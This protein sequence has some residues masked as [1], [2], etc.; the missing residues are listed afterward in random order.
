MTRR[1][2]PGNGWDALDGVQPDELP[3]VTVVLAHYDQQA[4]LDRSLAALAA[5]DYPAERVQVVVADD[6]SPEAPTVP[7]GVQLVRQADRGFRLAAVRNLGAAHATGEVL[8]FIDADCAPEPGYLRAATR[9]PAL[10]PEAVVVGRRRHAELDGVEGAIERIGPAHELE[11]PAWLR[12][13]YAGTRNLL[14]V[15]DRSYR[16]VIGASITTSR[17]F[18]ERVGGFDETFDA[19]GGEDWEWTHRAWNAGAVLAHEPAAVLWHNGPE[20]AERDDSDEAERI[21]RQNPESIALSRRIAVPGSAGRGVRAAHPHVL[22]ELVGEHRDTAVFATVDALL[23]ALPTAQ[24]AVP[25]ASAVLFPHDDRV[26]A[27][28]DASTR[29]GVL[30]RVHEPLLMADAGADAL[31]GLLGSLGGGA[32]E[33]V[34]VHDDGGVL[35]LDAEASRS[36][37]RRERWG[38]E[39]VGERRE[40]LAGVARLDGPLSL[41]ALLGG[42]SSAQRTAEERT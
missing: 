12:E 41:A 5:Q 20:F 9:L 2:V 8:C 40:R 38:E 19:Y 14:E 31:R 37:R 17:W 30:L 11:E 26:V 39:A 28:A 42:W 36:T 21:E 13:A 27:H 7:D 24:V 22:V 25:S 29:A 34:L 4:D 1:W 15:D 3:T 32:T 6:G 35:L 18:A 23:W 33:R 10:L 16:F